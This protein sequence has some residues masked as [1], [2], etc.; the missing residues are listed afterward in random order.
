[1]KIAVLLTCFNRRLKTISCL[2]SLYDAKIPAGYEFDVYLVD[3]GSTDGTKQAVTSEFPNVKVITGSGDL[4]WN[5]GMVLAWERAIAHDDYDFYLW[6]NDDVILYNSSLECLI[7]D[8]NREPNSIICG[9]VQSGKDKQITYGG[10]IPSGPKIVPNGEAQKCIEFNGN[11]VLVPKYVYQNIGILDSVYIH[12]IGDFDYAMRAY[13]KNISSF[14]AS[15]YVGTCES[16]DSAPAWCLPETNIFKRVK[17]LYSPLGN[18]HPYYFFIYE[19]R[20][21]GIGTAVKHYVSIH[22]RLL[23]PVVWN[24]RKTSW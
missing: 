6:L 18:S 22:L 15:E 12:A 14:V 24:W 16:H 17:S 10:S 23:F 2:K 9:S 11:V 21:F 7:R 3:D 5:R 1:M 8:H 4:Y 13:R 19:K 20:N